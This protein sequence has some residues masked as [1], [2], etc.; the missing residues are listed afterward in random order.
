MGDKLWD[1]K[2]KS[3]EVPHLEKSMNKCITVQS[4]AC[5]KI[6]NLHADQLQKVNIVSGLQSF[7]PRLTRF[8]SLLFLILKMTM[9]VC[10][11]AD[12]LVFCH[13][14]LAWRQAIV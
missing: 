2:I 4:F 11:R 12:R 14:E 10:L 13:H 1:Q 6:M 9:S 8:I 3:V 7:T 5:L